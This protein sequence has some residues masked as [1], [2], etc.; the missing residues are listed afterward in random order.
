MGNAYDTKWTR[1]TLLCMSCSCIQQGLVETKVI[2]L[3]V[4]LT[5]ALLSTPESPPSPQT[6]SSPLSISTSGVSSLN[7]K[8]KQKLSNLSGSST[9]CS[10]HSPSKLASIPS[11]PCPQLFPSSQL[12][13]LDCKITFPLPYHWSS[14]Q[15]I[16]SSL[17]PLESW[18]ALDPSWLSQLLEASSWPVSSL[19]S[20]RLS[21]SPPLLC[22]YT[23][24]L[25]D[26][27]YL[28]CRILTCIVKTP[29]HSLWM[30]YCFLTQ[31]T[32]L[33]MTTHFCFAELL[34]LHSTRSQGNCQSQWPR[35]LTSGL[36][37]S[38]SFLIQASQSSPRTLLLAEISLFPLEILSLS[39]GE[40]L[41]AEWSQ[42]Q[43]SRT[44]MQRDRQMDRQAITDI[45]ER[46]WTPRSSHA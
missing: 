30:L 23:V 28:S 32:F 27:I 7:Q 21:S 4:S 35:P 38:Y 39:G 10:F 36:G 6:S 13:S 15:R 37:H 33:G 16:T 19:N 40:N 45:I 14:L 41:H 20:G 3:P 43:P 31:N 1:W 44:E 12:Q 9:P 22:L 29:W 2:L 46:H 24:S 17:S 42:I 26:V 11:P 8:Q 5:L 34:I 25:D 18:V